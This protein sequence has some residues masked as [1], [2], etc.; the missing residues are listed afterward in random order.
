[1]NNLQKIVSF[2][3]IPRSAT[4]WKKILERRDLIEWENEKGDRLAVVEEPRTP[5]KAF[6]FYRVGVYPYFDYTREWVNDKNR[7]EPQ[8]RDIG[9]YPKKRQAIKRARQYME[10]GL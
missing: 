8:H 2:F 4:G 6:V 1:M 7:K 9:F 3:R 5:N 10:E